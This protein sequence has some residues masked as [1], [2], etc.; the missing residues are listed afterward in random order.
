MVHENHEQYMTEE[1]RRAEEQEELIRLREQ[2]K[3][4]E[5]ISKSTKKLTK[6]VQRENDASSGEDVRHKYAVGDVRMDDV[7]I[8]V[9]MNF[10]L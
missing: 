8:E 2:Q 3:W 6:A 10:R 7:Q 5:R 1:D 4:I 9:E